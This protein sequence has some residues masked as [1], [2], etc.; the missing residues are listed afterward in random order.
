MRS[1]SLSSTSVATSRTRDRPRPQTD[2]ERR[3]G[4][5]LRLHWRSAP[6]NEQTAAHQ[7][8]VGDPVRVLEIFVLPGCIACG[9]AIDLAERLRATHLP[10][11]LIHLIDVSRPG[12]IRP[13]AVFAV[14]TY[15]LDGRVVSLGNPDPVWL[16]SQLRQAP[17]PVR[18]VT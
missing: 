15:V 2:V 16:S 3:Y 18:A 8:T 12:T 7:E 1:A 10:G 5:T 14:P 6:T 11:V 4:D 9:T 13:A 17:L